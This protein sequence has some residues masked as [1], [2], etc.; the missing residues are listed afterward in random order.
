MEITKIKTIKEL[1]DSGYESRD[2]KDE[3]ILN[4]QKNS[5][6]WYFEF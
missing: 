6:Q 1:K 2:I 3:M 4:L 5:V